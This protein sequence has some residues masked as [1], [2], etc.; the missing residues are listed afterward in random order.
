MVDL[1]A[2]VFYACL[3]PS[4]AHSAVRRQSN[5]MASH[6]RDDVTPSAA[7]I[8]QL[9]LLQCISSGASTL[10][11]IIYPN[12]KCANGCCPGWNNQER[13]RGAEQNI[14]G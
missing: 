1:E 14:V 3:L 11:R 4:F 2:I 12:K 9:V 8:Y 5:S 7:K 13:L 10:A 6:Q